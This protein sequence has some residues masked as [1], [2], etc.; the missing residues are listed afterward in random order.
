MLKG[1]STQKYGPELKAFAL[2]L[3]FFSPRAYDF[4]RH[5]IS[6]FHTE[7]QYLDGIRR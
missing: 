6:L 7:E 3:S 5:S 2:S 4:V 1:P